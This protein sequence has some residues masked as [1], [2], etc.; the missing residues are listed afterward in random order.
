MAKISKFRI[1][2]VKDVSYSIM[3]P[4][5]IYLC[6][7]L[8]FMNSLACIGEAFCDVAARPLLISIPEAHTD[9]LLLPPTTN[10]NSTLSFKPTYKF[11]RIPYIIRSI[12]SGTVPS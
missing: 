12:M 1:L 4:F 8:R 9:L 2:V 11:Q 7:V 10:H 5:A 6:Q 3:L